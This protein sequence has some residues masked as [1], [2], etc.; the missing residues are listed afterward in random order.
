M[1]I[2]LTTKLLL[3][4]MLILSSFT[5]LAQEQFESEGTDF[6]LTFM[7]NY[8]NHI[9]GIYESRD[10]LYIFITSKYPTKG[11]IYYNEVVGNNT[12]PKEHHFEITQP[13]Q[14]YTFPICYKKVA[15]NGFNNSGQIVNNLSE[16]DC[17]VVSQ[18]SFRVVTEEKSTV[19]ALDYAEMTADA[20]IV[21]P[22]HTLGKEYFVMSYNS[23]GRT[24]F[25]QQISGQSTPSQFAIVAVKD[26]TNI[27]IYP[28]VSTAKFGMDKQ[29]ITLNQ[30]E[31]YLVQT[32]ITPDSLRNDLSGTHIVADKEIAVFGGH[33]RTSLPANTA[34]ISRD[35]LIIQL[36]SVHLWGR[37]AIIT[38][39]A[40]PTIHNLSNNLPDIYRVMA[41][42]NNTTIYVNET[43]V[44][45][46][47]AGEFYEA[48]L[49][50]VALISSNNPIMVAQ[51]K[52]S[53]ALTASN[54]VYGD[55][56]MLIVPPVEQYKAD[57]ICYK[58]AGK[59]WQH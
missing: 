52:K 51:Y 9:Q 29:N 46:L 3:A 59:N 13:N 34:V 8:H 47:D 44:A 43:T 5:V 25:N 32:K 27:T 16:T 10:S 54:N 39:F 35:C 36:I 23:D 4:T 48:E 26:N 53:E 30:G 55:P 28:K 50:E 11:I 58:S 40:R 6:W 57:Y 31:V 12:T 45:N 1:K 42:K 14:I 38:P 17:E 18:K 22:V 2:Q 33:Q 49:K 41:A 37:N 56:L 15:L 20:F 19:Y 21:L 24:E 7:P